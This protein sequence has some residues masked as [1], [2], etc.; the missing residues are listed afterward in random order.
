MADKQQA[1]ILKIQADIADAQKKIGVLHGGLDK[2][3]SVG[4]AITRAFAGLGAAFS[5]AAVLRE[6][7]RAEQVLAQVEARIK[8]TGGA[9]GFT[10]K[11]LAEMAAGFQ[12][13]TTFGDEEILE[14]Q[15]VLLTF[16]KVTGENFIAATETVLNMSVALNQ[17][18]KSAAIQ[19]GKAL[20]D[21]VLGVTSLRRAG[22][23]LSATQEELIK[24]LVRT[25]DVA[26]AQNIILR[27][28]ETQF[29]GAARAARDTLGGAL[30]ALKNAFSDLLEAKDGLR[31]AQEEIENL[32]KVLEDPRTQDAVNKLTSG[33]IK[34]FG[35]VV[36]K[37]RELTEEADRFGRA[38]GR[39]V[40]GALDPIAEVEQ[41]IQDFQN[42]K[43][44]SILSRTRFGTDFGLIHV[45][46]DEEIDIEIKRLEAQ[47]Q[48]LA[49]AAGMV[50]QPL[51]GADRPR[52]TAP[53][54]STISPPAEAPM[55]EEAAK[56]ITDLEKRIALLGKETVAEQILFETQR[57]RY[58]AESESTKAILIAKAQA[59]DAGTEELKTTKEI[60][61]A[62]E[63][64]E[65]ALAAAA[66]R[67]KDQLD[68]LREVQ[69]EVE[70]LV[71]MR[72]R[73]LLT[74][75]QYIQ[76]LRVQAQRYREIQEAADPA[77]QRMKELAAQ[78]MKI[79]DELSKRVQGA[80]GDELFNILDGNFKNIGD[81]FV[82]MLKRMAAELIA[83]QITKG[84]F[85][86]AGGIFG[87]LHEGGV[88]GRAGA[89]REVSPL[90]F[91][92]APRLHEGGAFGLHP[93]EIP[94]I[95]QRGEV[96]IPADALRR[97]KSGD[98]DVA[99][100][101][102]VENHG[103]PIEASD[104]QTSVDPEGIVLRIITNDMLRGGPIS[105]ALQRGRR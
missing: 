62:V 89:R 23:Q 76:A 54:P 42:L 100:K 97:G 5:F 71:Q 44:S 11:Q 35:A 31:D 86:G 59:L 105:G 46:T 19:V 20:Q 30:K 93:D 95:A 101:V 17:D 10:T 45:F 4:P 25:G 88:V 2:L 21:P 70:A 74:E 8:S 36:Q 58:A 69:R 55:S 67:V 40:H 26:G 98:V 65:K 63:A 16:T 99:V 9:A 84:I 14:M 56:A 92:G 47:R 38:V 79:T 53:P 50:L 81:S 34:G 27:E 102:I 64:N 48:Q 15:S 33:M 75:E 7:A 6:T 43:G 22:V 83:A 68:P 29:G 39:F 41:K 61:A 52:R 66:E 94:I 91:I 51:A 28:L 12:K 49:E 78:Q 90:A 72:E 104:A 24:N 1:L 60:K 85:G 73:G 18:L 32:T 77:M 3:K 87:I 82:R 37:M 96:V 13:A 103:A 80:L 57:G